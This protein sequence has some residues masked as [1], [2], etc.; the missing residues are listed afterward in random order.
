[1]KVQG[2]G[3]K[4]QGVGFR[5]V[6][7]RAYQAFSQTAFRATSGLQ[8]DVSGGAL[9]RIWWGMFSKVAPRLL[10]LVVFSSNDQV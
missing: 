4:V 10:K 5:E 6:L 8:G 2:S 7:P 9:L 3:L 1:M